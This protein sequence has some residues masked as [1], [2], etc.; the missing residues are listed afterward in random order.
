[1][2]SIRA[3]GVGSEVGVGSGDAVEVG[4]GVRLPVRVG[5]GVDAPSESLPSEEQPVRPTTPAPRTLITL[6]L[7]IILFHVLA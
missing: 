6:L 4:S 3:V 1:V 7:S 2:A 5:V